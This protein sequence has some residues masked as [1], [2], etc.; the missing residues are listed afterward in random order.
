MLCK[1]CPKEYL[2][3]LLMFSSDVNKV[4]VDGRWATDILDA[5]LYTRTPYKPT[6]YIDTLHIGRLQFGTHCVDW[7]LTLHIGRLKLGPLQCNRLPTCLFSD[8][9]LKCKQCVLHCLVKH[10]LILST[11]R[12]S[13]VIWNMKAESVTEENYNSCKHHECLQ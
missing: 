4:Y 3:H 12:N 7:T 5:S 8:S 11:P 9:F 13:S 6:K 1:D 10:F 2:V